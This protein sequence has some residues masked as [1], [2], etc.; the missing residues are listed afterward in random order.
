VPARNF[1]RAKGT[2]IFF[3]VRSKPILQGNRPL[4]HGREQR[5]K[6]GIHCYRRPGFIGTRSELL[7]HQV[8]A[9]KPSVLQMVK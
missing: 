1:H 5:V 8:N 7:Q 2:V 6:A 9:T 4:I 3:A